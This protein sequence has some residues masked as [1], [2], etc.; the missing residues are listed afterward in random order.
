MIGEIAT[1]EFSID[2]YDTAVELWKKVE[3]VEIAEGDARDEVAQYLNRNPGLSRVATMK[4][5]VVAVALCG[6]DGRRGYIY[7]LAVDPAYQ[8]RGIAKLLV[9]EC[10][11]GLRRAGLTRANI[12]VARDNP[13]GREFWRR[14]GWE[15]LDEV[16]AMA[17]D[18]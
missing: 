14:N 10:L 1:R 17:R 15:E 3:G 7:H 5:G 4:S 12:L 18:V 8:G 11:D 9:R 6:H 2:D 13:I 16:S